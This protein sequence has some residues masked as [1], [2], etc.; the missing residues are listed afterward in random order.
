MHISTLSSAAS[1]LSVMYKSMTAKRMFTN[2]NEITIYLLV[3]DIYFLIAA[4]MSPFFL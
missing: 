3:V 2:G 1:H 4:Y